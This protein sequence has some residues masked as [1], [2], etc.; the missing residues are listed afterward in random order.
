VRQTF[1]ETAQISRIVAGRVRSWY[2]RLRGTRIGPKA[3]LGRSVRFDFPWTVRIGTRFIAEADVWFKVVRQDAVV[4]VGKNV[5]IGRGTEINVCDRVDIG[6]DVAIAPG[7]FLVDHNHGLQKELRISD[8]PCH[9]SPIVIGDD[10]W[11]GAHAIILPGVTIGP[12]AVVA[13]GAC[14]NRDVPPGAIVG[15]VPAQII[16]YRRPGTPTRQAA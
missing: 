15:G 6:D 8:Q 10:T 1:E 11:L 4:T 16:G 14:V 2:W 5:F 7:C 9:S 13:A 12:K 3:T